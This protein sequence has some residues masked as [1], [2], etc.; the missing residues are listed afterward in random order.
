MIV[1]IG[2]VLWLA[3][4]GV[5]VA[6][7]ITLGIAAG[8]ASFA[9][10]AHYVLIVTTIGF[11]IMLS[12]Y[13]VAFFWAKFKPMAFIRAAI[14]AHKSRHLNT[15]LA[16]VIACD[17]RGFEAAGRGF[18][19]HRHCPANG[20]R[21]CP[22]DQ[23][24]DELGVAIYVAHLAANRIDAAAVGAWRR[25][26]PS[27]QPSALSACPARSALSPPSRRSVLLVMELVDHW[28][29]WWRLKHSPILCVPLVTSR[30]ILL[31]RE[32]SRAA[33]EI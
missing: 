13:P 22:R 24:R 23:P 2:W 5:F 9:N 3:P 12:A 11:I 27:L 30:W 25:S 6:L 29:C 31:S 18:A 7:G 4:L 21:H 17:G 16:G 8:V 15:K 19:E 28:V 32:P 33:K 26:R 1:V 14:P 10:L 20:R